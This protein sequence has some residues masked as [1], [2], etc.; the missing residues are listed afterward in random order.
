MTRCDTSPAPW[1]PAGV[2]WYY[3]DD[4]TA[5][6]HGDC[7]EL[8]G[9]LPEVA[10]V[11]TDPPY[12]VTT[13]DWD[14]PVDGWLEMLPT[15]TLWCFGSLRSLMADAEA[16]RRAGWALAQDVVWEKHNGSTFHADRFRRVHELVA[17]FY[18]GE[19]GACYKAPPV[20][21]NATARTVRSKSRPPH[22]GEIERRTY[23]SEDG[24]PRLMRSVLRVASCHGSAHHPTQKPIGV[25]APL[26][27]FSIPRGG[28]VL[29]PFMGSG[30][31]LRAAKDLGRK[32]VG[33][34]LEERY[35]EVA[36]KRLGQEVM[37]FEGAS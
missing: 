33:I 34:E 4:H 11:V 6:A 3:A 2:D 28:T 31:T 8:L 30:S 29:D 22:M 20:T 24:G 36:A 19:W 17:H 14:T 26:I 7:R 35:C 32:A 13:L 9:E 15:D 5:I 25:L 18:R 10:G 21:Y 16:F 27:E 37:D 23:V 1:P 12:G